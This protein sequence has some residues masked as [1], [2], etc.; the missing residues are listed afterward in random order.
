MIMCASP[1]TS[2]SLTVLGM[3]VDRFPRE[4]KAMIG[5]VPQETNLDTEFTTYDNLLVYSRYFGIPREVA[6]PG[7]TRSP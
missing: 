7:V 2:G 1:K 4:I 3:D 6:E 5:V